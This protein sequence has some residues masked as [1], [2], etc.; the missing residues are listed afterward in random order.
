MSSAPRRHHIV[1]RFYLERWADANGQIEIFDVPTG[2]FRLEDPELFGRIA[3]F[4]TVVGPDGDADYWIESQLLAGLDNEAARA[5]RSL[6]ETPRVKSHLKKIKGS[7]W[8]P[9]HLLSPRASTRFAMFMSA[10]AGRSPAFREAATRAT[11]RV[12]QHSLHEHYLGQITDETP[13]EARE[14]L[15]YMANLRILIAGFDQN[16]LPH[17]AAQL[18]YHLGEV[19]YAQYFWAVHRFERPALMLGDDPLLI[20]NDGELERSGSFGQVATAGH[21]PFS[22]WDKPDAVIARAVATLQG[23]DCVMLALDP[24]HLLVLTRPDR[25]VLPG[26][27]DGSESLALVYDL[28]LARASKQW[29][30][31]LARPA[32]TKR[33]A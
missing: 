19:L 3:D 17:L 14:H 8:H 31:R 4:N 16:T 10:Q 11:G 1:P 24:Y 20:V 5:M 30:C 28:L 15:E 33:A 7:G 18:T 29:L 6:G 25:L 22:L 21:E 12:I 27:Y 2:E 23:N 32:E 13:P 26:R 9:N